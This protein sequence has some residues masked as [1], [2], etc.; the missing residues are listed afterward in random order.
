MSKYLRGFASSLSEAPSGEAFPIE[1]A[2]PFPSVPCHEWRAEKFHVNEIRREHI[3][4]LVAG[5]LD[6]PD[7]D[8]PTLLA[9]Q[10]LLG[11][12]TLRDAA[13]KA[14]RL[15]REF[16]TMLRAEMQAA[17]IRSSAQM[18]EQELQNHKWQEHIYFN[19]IPP[20][21]EINRFVF[22]NAAI[23]EAMKAQAMKA[24]AEFQPVC[25]LLCPDRMYSLRL[26]KV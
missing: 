5:R 15:R 7:V 2:G 11:D 24:S 23:V 16:W 10:Y 6:K 21:P 17:W 12:S 14:R 8:L 9:F 1:P 18:E 3:A 4:R 13:E 20:A 22:A 19:Q 26:I 25:S